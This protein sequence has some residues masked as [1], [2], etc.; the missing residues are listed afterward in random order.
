MLHEAPGY[1]LAKPKGLTPDEVAAEAQG[2]FEQWMPLV[3]HAIR[4][5]ES[6]VTDHVARDAAFMLHQAVERAYHCVL[7]VLTAYSIKRGRAN[8]RRV[9]LVWSML[10]SALK[11]VGC[12]Y[13]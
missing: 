1:P 2:Y 5:A 10:P 4:L 12:A 8:R 3:Q 11:Q 7:L 9:R 13:E 6:S